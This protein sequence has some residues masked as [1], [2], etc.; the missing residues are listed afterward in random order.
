MLMMQGTEVQQHFFLLNL[1]GTDVVL[2]MDWLASLGK[3]V[4]DFEKLTL[5]WKKEG[6]RNYNQG[7][8]TLYRAQSSWKAILKVL[9][10]EGEGYF[11]DPILAAE[12]LASGEEVYKATSK[13]LEEFEDLFQPPRTTAL[14]RT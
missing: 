8:P 5:E 7:D 13:I 6:V 3:I 14:E 9:K 12:E 10:N 2:G 11:V 4:A 1:G